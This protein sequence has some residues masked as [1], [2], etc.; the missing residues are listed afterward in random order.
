MTIMT[1]LTFTIFTMEVCWT[2]DIYY[3]NTQS[4][5]DSF[6]MGSL[7]PE[8]NKRIALPRTTVLLSRATHFLL[9]SHGRSNSK[10]RAAE[11]NAAVRSRGRKAT[12]EL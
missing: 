6:R 8:G 12:D 5:K 10:E 1:K 7:S 3:L 9:N 4:L 2:T 11:K